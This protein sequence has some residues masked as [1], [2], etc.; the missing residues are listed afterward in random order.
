MDNDRKLRFYRAK[1]AL[2]SDHHDGALVIV[3]Y[4]TF[5]QSGV[6][7]DVAHESDEAERLADQ[8]M[9]F[10][11]EKDSLEIRVVAMSFDEDDED[12]NDDEGEE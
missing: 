11:R 4:D 5:E 1:A 6:A 3:L 2:A 12:D 7:L 10:L 8:Y 9:T